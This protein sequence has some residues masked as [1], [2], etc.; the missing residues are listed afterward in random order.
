M[1]GT[2][3]LT[4][5][6]GVRCW[7]TYNQWS[8]SKM[9]KVKFKASDGREGT[10]MIARTA[11]GRSGVGSGKANDGTKFDFFMGDSISQVGMA[12]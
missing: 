2:F 6:D 5:V 1:T 12:W 8:E 10:A 9:L 11:G 3:E 7:G 4:S